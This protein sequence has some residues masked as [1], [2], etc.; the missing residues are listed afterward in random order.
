MP[1]RRR[2]GPSTPPPRP[3]VAETGFD[4]CI[5]WRL[6][7]PPPTVY[8]LRKPNSVRLRSILEP[9]RWYVHR[10]LG[11]SGKSAGTPRLRGVAARIA[12][13]IALLS[14]ALGVTACGS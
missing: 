10:A 6:N 3:R 2:F 5:R 9:G 12:A 11:E 14:L 1:C 8:P 4:K 7:P 13:G